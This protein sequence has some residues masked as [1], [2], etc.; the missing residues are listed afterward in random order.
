DKLSEL[1]NKEK[2]SV[3]DFEEFVEKRVL[4]IN[5]FRNYLVHGQLFKNAIVYK[6]SRV[7][8]DRFLNKPSVLY[9]VYT[10]LI[11]MILTK[12]PELH[13]QK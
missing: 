5:M 3:E 4:T 1:L 9:A 6:G 8:A 13:I 7:A 2:Y 11:T 10:L 12:Y